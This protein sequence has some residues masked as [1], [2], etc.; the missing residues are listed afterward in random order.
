M[1]VFALLLAGLAACGP[2]GER[3][4]LAMSASRPRTYYVETDGGRTMFFETGLRNHTDSTVTVH[5]F[6]YASDNL[7]TPPARAVYPP[8]ALASMPSD[9]RFAIARTAD[10]YLL[11]IP[12]GDSAV[13]RGVLPM[14]A[15]WADGRAVRS[16]GYRDLAVYA[17]DRDGHTAF[18]A[19]WPLRRFR[20]EAPGTAR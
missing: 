4:G 17:Y 16:D 2:P 7:S 18:T 11:T 3:P 10:G 9:R 6:A 20:G 5:A 19:T 8:R 1:R 13:F 14:P 12:P 15:T